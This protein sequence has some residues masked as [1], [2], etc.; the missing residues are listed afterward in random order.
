LA[1]ATISELLRAYQAGSNVQGEV[2]PERHFYYVK[3][4]ELLSMWVG[5]TE[6]AIRQVFRHAKETSRASGLPVLIFW[7]EI[8]SL[9][10]VRGSRIS[11]S[12]DATIVPT[13]LSEMEGLETADGKVVLIGATNRIDV[14]DPAMLRPG[15]FDYIVDVPRPN[16][17][18]AREIL[19]LYL[20]PSLPYGN[21][22][23]KSP[24]ELAA[25][26]LDMAVAYVYSENEQENRLA[27]ILFRDGK[28]QWVRRSDLF[29][30]AVAKNVVQKASR[31]ALRR[32]LASKMKG[33]KAD[34]HLVQED[35]VR[36][37]LPEDLITSIQEELGALARVLTPRNIRSYLEL[38]Q[39]QDVVAVEPVPAPPMV[40]RFVRW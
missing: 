20:K 23:G 7:D 35:P 28:R 12:V 4:P 24:E 33:S 15:R 29:S 3:G 25:S 27:S 37:I 26:L 9:I 36:G 5:Q 40:H 39:D 11:S 32:E 14:V 13:F 2:Q 22:D 17:A 21:R 8:E 6:R 19:R 34:L 31:Q 1:R 10:P 38:P 30:G 18:A 16:R